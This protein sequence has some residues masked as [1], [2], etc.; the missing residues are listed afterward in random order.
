MRERERERIK[1]PVLHMAFTLVEILIV[2]TIIGI[3]ATAILPRVNGILERAKDL[4]RKTGLQQIAAALELY[5]D[6]K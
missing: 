1:T 6:A 2:V 3:L 4:Q 5:K